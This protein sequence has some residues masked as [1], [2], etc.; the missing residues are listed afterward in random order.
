MP[1]A[2]RRVKIQAEIDK[3]R[4]KLALQQSKIRALET[5]RTEYENMEIVDIVRGLNIPLDTLAAALQV[6]KAGTVS[7]PAPASGQVGPKSASLVPT[8]T[9]TDKEDEIE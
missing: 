7:V 8:N 5:K 4:E 1:K 2:T 9:K 3:A 6:L